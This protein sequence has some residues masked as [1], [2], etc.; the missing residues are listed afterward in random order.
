MTR[1]N[2]SEIAKQNVDVI[3]E[4]RMTG[5]SFAEIAQYLRAKGKYTSAG[6]CQ[7]A[8]SKYHNVKTEIGG[9]V[10]DS[11][12]EANRYQELA[13][14]QKAGIVKNL[15]CQKRFL[16]IPKTKDERSV[17]YVADFVYELDGRKICE[18]VKSCITRKNTTYIIKRKLFKHLYPDWEFKET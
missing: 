12:K 9:R 5:K 14:L 17:Y 4:K 13:M 6:A 16:I 11:K 3:C 8:Y 2:L 10:F 18:D 1:D 7:R 15:E